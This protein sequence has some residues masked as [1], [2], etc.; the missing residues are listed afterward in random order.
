[1]FRAADWSML[2]ARDLGRIANCDANDLRIFAD[3]VENGGAELLEIVWQGTRIGCLIWSQEVER[4]GR[5]AFVINAAAAHPVPELD[6][7]EAIARTFTALARD[8]GAYVVRCWT[9][10]E[11]LRH[12]LER[13][14][15]KRH[16]V[17]ELMA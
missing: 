11:G 12:K 8:A 2:A 5:L 3:S 16:Y 4:D 6:I 10:R 1:M 17:M 7:S 14:G 15:A 9:Q 13:M